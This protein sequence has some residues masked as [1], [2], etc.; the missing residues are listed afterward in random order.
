MTSSHLQEFEENIK[1]ARDLIDGGTALQRQG[2]QNF[3][4][5]PEDLY[6]AAW[7]QAIS[8]MDHW[9]HDELID[10][11]VRLANDLGNVRTPRMNDLKVPFSEV[12]RMRGV[13]FPVVFRDFLI[14]EFERRSFHGTTDISEGMKLV[15]HL[16]ADQVWTAVGRASSLTK[17]Q[18]KQRHND[19]VKR[20][21]DISHRAD[22]DA[23]GR[24]QPMASGEVTATVDW[25][26]SLVHELYGLLG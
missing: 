1:Y 20:R 6:R 23:S 13:S 14:K 18:A 26:D 10:R 8:A 25:I 2:L 9:L 11:A 4:A 7:S 22:R 15:C 5:H 3:P 12:E 16:T 19:I 24:R 21:N 17:E